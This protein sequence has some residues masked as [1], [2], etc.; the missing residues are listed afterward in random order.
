MRMAKSALKE[1]GDKLK[2]PRWQR[3]RLEVMQRDG[4]ACLCCGD[5]KKTLNVN[6]LG[7]SGAPWDVPLEWLETLCEDCH[8]VWTDYDQK[9]GRSKVSTREVCVAVFRDESLSQPEDP[10]RENTG[11]VLESLRRLQ[12][13]QAPSGP[14]AGTSRPAPGS[15]PRDESGP[16]RP[17]EDALSG[18]T[19]ETVEA[20]EL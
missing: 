19:R 9:H 10:K 5:T 17:R 6:H 20:P 7:Y 1:Y 3:V 13:R 12:K 2:D 11:A 16:Q 14:G 18:A 15:T 4:F 8:K